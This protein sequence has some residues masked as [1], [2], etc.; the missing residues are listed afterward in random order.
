MLTSIAALSF[1]VAAAA[2]R[3]RRRGLL[4]VGGADS[5]E[6][7]KATTSPLSPDKVKSMASIFASIMAEKLAKPAQPVEAAKP[8]ASALEAKLAAEMEAALAGDDEPPMPRV[9]VSGTEVGRPISEVLK[10]GDRV[11]QLRS[12]HEEL[13]L[14]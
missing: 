8:D 2:V 6:G 13:E 5:E 1:A 4:A 14:T 10:L 3:S 12:L 11:V 9:V 7:A